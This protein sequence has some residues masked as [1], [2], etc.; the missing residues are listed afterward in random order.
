[1][2]FTWSVIGS[3]QTRST[4]YLTNAKVVDVESGTISEP[5]TI[6]IEEG[7]IKRIVKNLSIPPSARQIDVQGGFVIPGMIDAHVHFFQSGGLYTRPDAID[8]THIKPYNDERWWLYDNFEDLARRYLRAGVT[9]V[10][11]MGGPFTNFDLRDRATANAFLP[12]L[13]VTGPLLST[14]QPEAFEIDDSP[15]IKVRNEQDAIS[16]IRDQARFKPDFIKVWYIDT[17]D[18]PAASNFNLV[19]AI[20]KESH[21]LQLKVAVHATELETA[22][23]AVRAGADFLVHSV[24]EPI[25]SAF[26]ELLKKNKVSLI[27]TLTVRQGYVNTLTQQPKITEVDH[28]I[29]NPYVLNSMFDYRMLEDARVTLKYVKDRMEKRKV[30]YAQED[31]IQ[32]QNLLRL[33]RAGVV[34]GAGTDAGNIGTHH[35]SSYHAELSAMNSA[36]LSPMEVLKCATIN[37]AKILNLDDDLGTI[38]K[39]KVA[40][41]CILNADPTKNVVHPSDIQYVIK[42]GLPIAADS[43]LPTSPSELVQRQLVAYN[44]RDIDAFL[45]V[46]SDSVKIYS[47]DGELLMDGKPAMRER[48]S[49]LFK[50]SP[51]LHCELVDRMVFGNIVIDQEFVR[52]L[53]EQSV[54]ALAVY[55]IADGAISIVRFIKKEK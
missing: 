35:G 8:L 17:P 4:L 16:L 43:I 54:E 37:A 15:I 50:K 7:K 25:D 45:S 34:I 14:Y 31:S 2:F 36:G 1:M 49:E 39:G 11:D 3:T 23:L 42:N 51:E 55:T 27:P 52:G 9:T 24:S 6:W 44:A 12:T 48:Y 46:Y 19:K 38:E 53:R 40:D 29:A 21:R 28:L 41:L 22:K 18:E 47:I 20:V 13:K 32:K 26:I 5:S 30:R 33:Y 10:Y